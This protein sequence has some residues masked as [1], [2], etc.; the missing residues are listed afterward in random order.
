MRN[1]HL[2]VEDSP[3][4]LLV[5]YKANLLEDIVLK[6]C[7]QE[8]KKGDSENESPSLSQVSSNEFEPH[9]KPPGSNGVV[10]HHDM[11]KNDSQSVQ[12]QGFV[13][14]LI[15]EVTDLSIS[16]IASLANKNAIFMFRN[17]L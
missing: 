2:L 14:G 16:R 15:R 7:L 4:A 9:S 13:Q 11:T 17:I 5:Q 6:L 8:E 1:G 12:E 3:A 10:F